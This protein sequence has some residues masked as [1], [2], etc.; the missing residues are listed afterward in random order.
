M[1]KMGIV[2]WADS[3]RLIEKGDLVDHKKNSFSVNGL[4]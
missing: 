4:K 1:P 2:K 3:Y